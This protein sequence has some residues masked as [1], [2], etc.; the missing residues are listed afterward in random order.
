MA[1]LLAQKGYHLYLADIDA[2]GLDQVAEELRQSFKVNVVSAQCDLSLPGAAEAL[3]QD[4]QM[5]DLQVE[6]LCSNAGF[7]F[8]GQI[9][10]ADPERAMKMI[11][12][13]VLTTSLLAV[14]FGKEMRSKGRGYIMMTSSISAYQD[15]PGIG[16][17]GASKSYIKSFGLSLRHE[18]RYYGVN[19]TVLCPGATATNL[20][21]PKV[22]DVEKGK[23][24]GIM[25]DASKVAKA[26][27][28]GMFKG[29]AII[30][31]GLMTKVMTYTSALLPGWLI[32][33]V[34]VKWRKL[35]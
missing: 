9:A 28:E 4:V 26:G 2:A 6:V 18:L 3:Y 33:W 19:V 8:F 12:L 34:R 22:I 24:W 31:P 13:H 21:D 1:K 20:Y 25:M 16:F 14:Y 27:I 7:F 23:R 32:F 35:L 29:K 5:K 15:F 11:G 17:Y 10:N 30:M